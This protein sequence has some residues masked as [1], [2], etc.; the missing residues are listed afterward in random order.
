MKD[1][2]FFIFPSPVLSLR[3]WS[4]AIHFT[5]EVSYQNIIFQHKN[6]FFVDRREHT[7]K[8]FVE[9]HSGFFSYLFFP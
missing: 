9:I 2:I 4:S 6:I 7:Q 8:L 1:L 3:A 5:I